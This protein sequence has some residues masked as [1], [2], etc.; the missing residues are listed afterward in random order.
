MLPHRLKGE[1]ARVGQS[2]HGQRI[3]AI[4]HD[5]RALVDPVKNLRHSGLEFFMGLSGMIS[6]ELGYRMLNATNGFN[7]FQVERDLIGQLLADEPEWDGIL[8]SEAGLGGLWI[9]FEVVGARIG[10]H[11]SVLDIGLTHE[12][13]LGDLAGLH[14]P[15][16]ICQRPDTDSFIG[17]YSHGVKGPQRGSRSL[18]T[19]MIDVGMV[20]ATWKGLRAPYKDL[21]AFPGA[22][23][24]CDEVLGNSSGGFAVP[25]GRD[26]SLNG[27]ARADCVGQ[28]KSI[29]GVFPDIGEQDHVLS[30]FWILFL[31]GVNYYYSICSVTTCSA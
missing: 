7:I 1:Q 20:Q 23:Q 10:R 3:V 28:G 4:G 29:I 24:A 22:Q 19:T 17:G 9:T 14:E 21:G 8:E 25:A 5:I 2:H 16:E 27:N 31:T 13:G 15:L 6:Q 26:D 18:H 30:P 12:Q 11:N